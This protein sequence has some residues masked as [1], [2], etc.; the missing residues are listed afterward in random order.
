MELSER[1]ANDT[2]S[3]LWMDKQHPPWHRDTCDTSSLPPNPTLSF[4]RSGKVSVFVQKS[5]YYIYIYI[6]QT[7][8]FVTIANACCRL[9]QQ[10]RFS[11]IIIGSRKNRGLFRCTWWESSYEA[12][13]RIIMWVTVAIS[14]I[15]KPI[16]NWIELEYHTD[17]IDGSWVYSN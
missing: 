1:G 14:S 7:T 4:D 6:Y 8:H 9:K 10:S 2:W 3:R 11:E 12:C 13:E 16:L 5:I 17:L 15:I